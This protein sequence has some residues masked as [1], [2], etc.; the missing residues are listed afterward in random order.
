VNQP[1]VD[2]KNIERI[3][4]DFIRLSQR[5]FHR[6]EA[7][8]SEI[9][10]DK[11]R[12][13]P[14][15]FHVNHPMLP[16]YVDKFTPCGIPNY[17]P[18]HLEKQIAKTVSQSFDYKP[19]AHLKYRIASLFLMGSMGTL[20]QSSS[21]DIDLWICLQETLEQKLKLK[22]LEKASRIKKWLAEFG[23]ELNA[24][25]VNHDE[26]SQKRTKKIETDNCGNTQNYLLLDE[27]YRT[28]V[29]ISGRW[30][31][32]W[33]IPNDQNYKEH[34]AKLLKQKH[35]DPADWI[36]FGEVRN[37]PASE[38]F[39][40][41]LWQLYKAIESPYKSSVKLLVL[42]VY[43]KLFPC[44]GVLSAEFKQL[45]YD[46][47][48]QEQDL[49]PYLL[50]LKFAEE[51]LKDNGHRLEFLY[52]AFYLKANIKVDLKKD[53]QAHWQ[54]QTLKKLVKSWGWSQAKLNYLN[55]RNRWT[56]KEVKEE[57]KNL[58]RELTNS[59]HFLSNFSR[60]HG[61]INRVAKNELLS[62]GRKLYS[63][64]ER[65][66][67]KIE[68]LNN[69]IAKDIFESSITIS[70]DTN[71][72][73][74][75]YI[76]HIESNSL[77]RTTEVNISQSLFESLIWGCAN[78][79]ITSKTRLHLYN[80]SDYL[81]LKL[82]NEML[83]D[84]ELL[85]SQF[86]FNQHAA[87]FDSESKV[88]KLGIFVN[89]RTDPLMEEK[90]SNVYRVGEGNDCFSWSETKI[91][92]AEH[93]DVVLLNSW[94][95]I[96]TKHYSGEFAWVEFYKEY[97]QVICE[98][99]TRFPVFCRGLVQRDQIVNRIEL[100]FTKLNTLRS[101]S[102]RTEQAHRYIMAISGKFHILD[103]FKNNISYASYSSLPK[104]YN[105][106]SENSYSD[107]PEVKIKFTLD[108]YLDFNHFI[109]AVLKRRYTDN[110]DFYVYYK[111]KQ[112]VEV[113]IR[114][115]NG[116]IYYHAHRNINISQ[117][118]NHYQQFFEKIQNRNL[119]NNGL[120]EA[121]NYFQLVGS[122]QQNNQRIKPISP[123]HTNQFMDFSLVQAIATQKHVNSAGFDMYT[124]NSC[125][126]Y[127]EH[128]EGVYQKLRSEILSLRK[129]ATNYPIFI[130]DIDLSAIG[131][132]V[133]IVESLI[134]KKTIE[135]KL[136]K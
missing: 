112:L 72:Q 14:L 113:I 121:I 88:V 28:A 116:A 132:E 44:G 36:D 5:R 33:I 74:K 58:V 84:I 6:M 85:L 18:S 21:S 71:G 31:L 47:H 82:A 120:L 45:V 26:F 57:R 73:W 77:A 98:Q 78:N 83:R 61:V 124:A 23:V 91:N 50:T 8:L 110:L 128:G 118:V 64:F 109:S 53:K 93:F 42:E 111:T 133:S 43:A 25:V 119:L 66:S 129:D 104:L 99:G 41:A 35:V 81:N 22:L 130:T 2:L 68:I 94:G 63:A 125:Y 40:A 135:S 51:A 107:Q 32:W 90:K 89:T 19:R 48:S 39:S 37:I 102:L 75:I 114:S 15:L 9:Q 67:G 79:I 101:N 117:V 30:P 49:D 34:S 52:R 123:K 4:K 100:L 134:Y 54:Y 86:E 108:D 62:L 87:E 10:A 3:K 65:R 1:E 20:G 122:L 60:V 92:L 17:T 115:A 95:E 13:L 80:T 24:Y 76:G 59:Y 127:S 96:S 46:G 97:A 11:L 103:I 69:G 16:G 131:S 38:Y 27:F 136:N 7:S 29:W 12:L 70:Q 106:L 126:L 56:I 105:G 55:E